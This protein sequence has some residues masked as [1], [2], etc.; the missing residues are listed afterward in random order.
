[1]NCDGHAADLELALPIADEADVGAPWRSILATDLQVETKPDAT[2]V[3][4]ADKQAEQ[5]DPRA[6]STAQRPDDGI[7]GEEFGDDGHAG[8]RWIV[9]PIDGTKNYMRG[10]PVWCTLLALE[11][12]GE[13]VVGVASA[14]ALGRRWWA[15]RRP[16][17]VH[18]RRGRHGPPAA[19][20]R[21]ARLGRRVV[22]A[23]PT[24]ST[25]HERGADDGT[26]SPDRHVLARPG[27]TVTSCRTCSGR[28]GCRRHR[29]RAGADALGHGRARADRHRERRTITAYRR[30][31]PP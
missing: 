14:P 10:V 4:E 24:R 21:G 22:L 3:T 15:A 1:M 28:R 8:R 6:T 26:A 17:R 12:D 16:G 25:G 5:T 27:P 7:L 20:Q 18:P 23:T 9:D 31:P 11:V 29:R 13:L 19:R 2:P 30:Q